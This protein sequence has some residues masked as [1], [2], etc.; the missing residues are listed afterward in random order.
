MVKLRRFVGKYLF[1]LVLLAA[2]LAGDFALS[3]LAPAYYISSGRFEL[4]DYELVRRD[5]PEKVWDRVFFGGAAV[6]SAYREDVSASGYVDL[7]LENA[8]V[9]DLL[10]MVRTGTITVGSDLV[11]GLD[12]STLWDGAAGDSAWSWRKPM[13]EPYCY[14]DRTRLRTLFNEA[15]KQVF[16]GYQPPWGAYSAQTRDVCYGSLSARELAETADPYAQLSLDAFRDN[17]RALSKL[18]DYCQGRGIRLRVVW[19]P[20]NPDAPVSDVTEAVRS[21]A[22]SLCAGAGVEFYDMG[23]ALD[24][25]CFYDAGRLNAEYGSYIFTKEIEAWLLS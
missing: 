6:I 3:V 16:S 18:A 12:V 5:H 23:G 7:G 19:M 15:V 17:L 13:Y 10:A 11:V 9:S 20:M 4:N 21:E 2:F 14:F 24:S 25:A 1:F 22:E 8:T